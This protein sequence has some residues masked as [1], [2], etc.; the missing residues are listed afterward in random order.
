MEPLTDLELERKKRAFIS[1]RENRLP[2]LGLS[3][4]FGIT[5]LSTWL[6]SAALLKIGLTQMPVRY[7][8]SI[9]AGYA[10]FFVA[11]RVWSDF[12]RRRPSVD[13][14]NTNWPDISLPV[15]DAEGCLFVIALMAVGV[16][17]AGLATWLG[18]VVMLEVAFEVAFAGLL[19]RRMGKLQRVGDWK[20]VLFQHTRGLV[21]SILLA[22]TVLAYY[23]QTKYP[24]AVKLSDVWRLSAP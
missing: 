6:C 22:T 19:V 20:K 10:M 18:A 24:Q 16:L 1:E 5:F 3:L 23:Y 7:G 21:V 4:V 12:Q 13:A 11:V 9:L 14:S 8:L 2:L 17:L 15:N